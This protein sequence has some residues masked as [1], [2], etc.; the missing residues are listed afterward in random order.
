MSEW[1]LPTIDMAQCTG[2]GLCVEYCPTQAVE[3][4][5]QL[6]A[7]LRPQDCSYCG[8]CEETCPVGAIALSYEIDILLPGGNDE[9]TN[10][11]N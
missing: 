4:R 7:I 10:R 5:E 8:L 2:C 1:A 6:P 9:T 3:L 11:P